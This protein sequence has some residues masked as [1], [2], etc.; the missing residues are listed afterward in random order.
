MSATIGDVYVDRSQIKILS[1]NISV[2][3]ITSI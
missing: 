1:L 3:H 2:E